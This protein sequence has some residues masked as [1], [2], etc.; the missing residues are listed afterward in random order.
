MREAAITYVKNSKAWSYHLVLKAEG[1]EAAMKTIGLYFHA[2]PNASVPALHMHIVDIGSENGKRCCGPTYDKLME[3][4][5]PLEDVLEVLKRELEDEWA[6]FINLY[7][8]LYQ[9]C[10]QLGVRNISNHVLTKQATKE[11]KEKTCWLSPP[12]VKG[13]STVP[14]EQGGRETLLILAVRAAVECDTKQGLSADAQAKLTELVEKLLDECPGEFIEKFINAKA[15]NGWSAVHAVLATTDKFNESNKVEIMNGKRTPMEPNLKVLKLLIAH[16]ANLLLLDKQRKSPL[17]MAVKYDFK[18]AARMLFAYLMPLLVDKS[19]ATFIAASLHLNFQP[20]ELFSGF[21]R[22][23]PRQPGSSL[24]SIVKLAIATSHAAEEMRTI[25]SEVRHKYEQAA[26]RCSS[27][28]IALLQTLTTNQLYELF[29][30]TR[31]GQQF[32]I[33]ACTTRSRLLDDVLASEQVF[34]T[35]DKRWDG[36]LVRTITKRHNGDG[37]KIV[38]WKAAFLRV[39]LVFWWLPL[40][41][42]LI[43]FI[44]L[45]PPLGN[46]LENK[47]RGGNDGERKKEIMFLKNRPFEIQLEWKAAFLLHSPR[48]VFYIYISAQLALVLLF[49]SAPFQPTFEWK[50]VLLGWSTLA[51]AGEISEVVNQYVKWESDWLNFLELP[52]LVSGFAAAVNIWVDGD[53]NFTRTAR[54]VMSCLL[55]SAQLFR[56]LQITRNFGPLVLMLKLML[57]DT[58]RWSLIVS[59]T[60]FSFSLSLYELFRYSMPDS[61]LD[62]CHAADFAVS[63]TNALPRMFVAMLGGGEEYVTCFSEVDD[64]PTS[65]IMMTTFL[66]LTVVI[67]MNMLIAMMSKTFDDI[68]EHAEKRYKVQRVKLYVSYSECSLS[69][70]PF[71]LLQLPY[72]IWE[73]AT[74]FYKWASS[75]QDSDE[76]FPTLHSCCAACLRK[77]LKCKHGCVS[78]F[79]GGDAPTRYSRMENERQHE[80]RSRRPQEAPAH[81]A[82]QLRDDIDSIEPALNDKEGSSAFQIKQWNDSQDPNVQVPRAN[83]P[84]KTLEWIDRLQR[85]QTEMQ[86]DYQNMA[87]ESALTAST[88][89]LSVSAGGAQDT[90]TSTVSKHDV[91]LTL[92]KY[93]QAHLKAALNSES[94]LDAVL[95][96]LHEQ[97]PKYEEIS[98]TSYKS[99]GSGAL[100]RNSSV[101]G[102]PKVFDKLEELGNE[103]AKLTGKV[104]AVLSSSSKSV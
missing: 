33:T 5:L 68:F 20:Y 64:S 100:F 7:D 10:V 76:L 96:A 24:L 73:G 42:L 36:A 50:V 3:K 83:L 75:E 40:N 41:L 46:M 51:L 4:N 32:L 90:R 59:V 88:D 89:E 37:S 86:Q 101:A 87:Q 49:M 93:V 18:Q 92:S 45:Y 43:P 72:M 44:A 84:R 2:Y 47:L 70:A 21:I 6:D 26:T 23:F 81:D 22:S 61:D 63:P 19:R 56:V 67:L 85:L 99:R 54:S 104:D 79:T 94:L 55:V 31:C 30:R 29:V 35:I 13:I 38:R 34:V 25:S 69:M 27:V 80:A 78:C 103:L 58:L 39:L 52:A 98:G 11:E 14:C 9:T 15:G 48:I 28:I 97:Q 62:D 66:T 60:L 65:S 53:L 57:L 74:S 82:A 8:E 12:L 91:F 77:V 95:R 71:N 1:E 17:A 102:P 16:G